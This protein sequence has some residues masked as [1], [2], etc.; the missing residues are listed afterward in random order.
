MRERGRRPGL[1]AT[2][3]ALALAAALAAGGGGCLGIGAGSIR[4][5]RFD[6]NH[7]L[8]E[9]QKQQALLNIVKLR[10]V[11]VPI[12]LDVAQIVSGYTFES[13]VSASGSLFD[14]RGGVPGVPDS[15]VTLGAQGRLTDRPTITYSPVTGAQ[16]SRNILTPLP[17]SAVLFLVQAGWPAD[18]VL[19]M[20]VDSINGLQNRSG[21]PARMHPGDAEFHR[22]L[23]LLRQ[24]QRSAALGVR[25]HHAPGG[26]DRLMISFRRRAVSPDVLQAVAEVGA[27]LG[28]APDQ[29][30]VRVVYGS[31]PERGDEIAM[32]TRS[33]IQML[34]ELSTQIEVPPEHLREQRAAPTLAD[35]QSPMTPLIRIRSG[36]E[37]PADA[38]VSVRY[39]DHW[40]WV[41]DRDLWSKRTFT[42]LIVLFSLADTGGKES[43]PLVT[44]PAG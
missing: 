26:P 36:A 19:S 9:S 24:I 2:S 38:Y 3:R 31:T 34:I 23:E 6:Y 12:F 20:V 4:R 7:A 42:F 37:R 21:A 15:A 40:Y 17:P 1:V 25:V 43:L 32:L 28:L 30:E 41:D 16:F 10:Y 33:M 8:S 29:A 39:R 35:G 13:A 44:I 14:V 5:D 27:L 22:L 11:D 18:F